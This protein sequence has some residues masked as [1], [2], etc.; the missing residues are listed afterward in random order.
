PEQ[1]DVRLLHGFRQLGELSHLRHTVDGC[2][3]AVFYYFTHEILLSNNTANPCPPPPHMAAIPYR[4]PCCFSAWAKVRTKRKPLPPKGWPMA[5]APPLT[6]I[7]S[8]GMDNLRALANTTEAKASL[9]SNKSMSS[10]RRP[11]F[12]NT[13]LM[14]SAGR[15]CKL[16]SGPA[17]CAAAST[18]ASGW[19]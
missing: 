6:L 16:V 18:C 3:P 13:A 4:L 14:A 12:F 1:F 15:K 17:V 10:I 8:K 9:I 5:I 19:Y 7:L 11:D 2:G